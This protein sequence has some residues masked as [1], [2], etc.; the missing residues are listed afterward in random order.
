VGKGLCPQKWRD[1]T[2]VPILKEVKPAERI[3]SYRPISLTSCFGKVMERMV[4][5]RLTHLAEGRGMWCDEQAGFR[6]L[7][8]T[9]DQVLR[10]TQSIGDGFQAKPAKRSVLA[11]LD[12]SKAYDTVWRA[13]LLG[14][15]LDSELPYPLIRW[16]WGFLTNRQARVRL[17]GVVSDVRAFPQGLP[18][19][20]VL[21]PLLFLFIINSLK[22]RLPD[23]LHVSL[24][25]DD[26]ALLASDVDKTE[27]ASRVQEG[28]QQVWGWSAER[29][30][31]LN[32]SK[33]EVSF[34]STDTHESKW[35]PEV[36]VGGTPLVFNPNPVFL[37]VTYDRTLSFR[38]HATK[39]AAKVVRGSR[40]LGAL[41]GREWGWNGRL[42]R[43]VYQ[44][45][46]LGSITYCAAGW[47]PWL[48]DSGVR[49]LDQAQN[50]CLRLVT[51][52]YS[53]SPLEALR[54]ESG[55]PS[56]WT[57]R[58]RSAA[59]A[60]ERSLRLPESNPRSLLPGLLVRHR[61]KIRSSW[62]VLASEVCEEIGL[63]AQQ[64]SPFPPVTTAPWRWGTAGWT[65]NP[66]LRGG[67]LRNAPAETRLADALDTIQSLG[68][69]DFTVFT[70]GSAEGGV[71]FGGSAA[72]ILCGPFGELQPVATR[73]ERGA[74]LTSSFE[75]EV[76]ALEM[77][78]DW[79]VIGMTGGSALVC[80]DSRSALVSLGSGS[81]AA[82][83]IM[84]K[85]RQS[86]R[87]VRGRVVFQWVPGH[88]GL[89]GNEMADQ[90]AGEA[91]RMR[92]EGGDWEA[93]PPAPVSFQAAK[94]LVKRQVFDSLP[95]HPRVRLVYAVTPRP[96]GGLSR[97]AE[98]A[99]AQ[100]RSGHSLLLGEYRA[101]V[102]Q[103][104]D[105]TCPRCGEEIETL[106][107]FMQEC[108]ATV[109]ARLS[110]FG[111]VRPPLSVLCG[112]I[113]AVTSYLRT[114]RVL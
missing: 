113:V 58:R 16:I 34:F 47:Q 85:L 86:L 102:G 57:I 66:D 22:A 38:P 5:N 107:H 19:G 36:M 15:L 68:Q 26:V 11:L 59:I 31:N 37:G 72:V 88:C 76:R 109:K 3:D 54:L 1:A 24:Y 14:A 44:T 79:L 91:S 98:V 7:R 30:L 93:V 51:G 80:S 65:V 96:A 20:S 52:L 4:A 74:V 46:L 32:L 97:K 50:R 105:A 2:I 100:L 6:G 27:A 41:S 114:L 67:S 83:P 104:V 90:A 10:I 81:S 84:G 43:R 40:V 13:D 92:T 33:C 49:D 103:G 78:V 18:Q 62:R 39:V 69:F 112:N 61:S 8:S 9:E 94:A 45:S 71:Q 111:E 23:S 28:V 75:T 82:N 21:S 56:V 77:A 63:N 42:L 53:S 25:A 106:Q 29:K 108:P 48:A 70:D 73:R 55:F 64:R 101:R 60:L 17:N 95:A 12:F 89:L 35:Q 87:D 99:V 110:A